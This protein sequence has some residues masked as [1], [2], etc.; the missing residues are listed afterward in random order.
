MTDTANPK[1][2]T[3]K[4]P[5]AETV[6]LSIKGFDRD[7]RCR[8]YQFAEGETFSHDGKVSLCGSGF[9][10]CPVDQHPLSVFEFYPPATSTYREVKQFGGTEAGGTKLVSAK[11]TIGVEIT[12]G[13]LVKRAWDYVWSRA[14]KTDESHAPGYQGA[15][16]APGYQG[17]ASATGDLGAASA[18]GDLGAASATGYQGAASATGTRGA[19]ISSYE[20]R[21]MGTAGNALF[22]IER[23]ANLDILSVACGIVGRDEVEPNT[24]YVARAGRLVT[25]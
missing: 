2:T 3:K 1:R 13:E 17:A 23:D 9:H 11:I 19:A 4:A 20:G 16:S 8:G 6:I 24:W 22:A 25:A 21:V 7:L 14:T 18:T 15:A 10:A 5:K 12:I